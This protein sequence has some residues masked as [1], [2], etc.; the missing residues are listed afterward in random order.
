MTAA[1][2]VPYNPVES[3]PVEPADSP[4]GRDDG[5]F[6]DSHLPNASDV[7]A[8]DGPKSSADTVLILK[9]LERT[10]LTIAKVVV[11]FSPKDGLLVA[12]NASDL[13]ESWRAL[14]DGDA[15]LRRK[16][17]SALQ[18]TGYGAVAAAHLPIALTIAAN[19]RDSFTHLVK[20]RTPNRPSE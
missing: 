8:V 12:Q 1:Q 18:A 13:A 10:Y 15:R 2:R 16:M 6:V 7:A 3:E 17:K 9:S 11:L 20:R 14:L 4:F 19:H 5:P